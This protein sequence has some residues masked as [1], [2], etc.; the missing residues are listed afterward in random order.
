MTDERRDELVETYFSM[1]NQNTSI[2]SY[3]LSNTL[4]ADIGVKSLIWNVKLTANSLVEQAGDDLLVK[5]GETIG[6]QSEMY[7]QSKRKLPVYVGSLHS[8]YRRI[9]FEI[10]EGYQVSNPENLRMKVEMI[11]NN[12]VSCAFTSDYELKGNRIIIHSREYYSELEYPIAEFEAFRGVVNA[13]A[14]FNKKTIL[15]TKR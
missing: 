5:V 15:L 12:R 8:Y 4:P 11:R 6:E 10:P 1:G 9:E 14:D 2:G 13:A 7:Q 3:E